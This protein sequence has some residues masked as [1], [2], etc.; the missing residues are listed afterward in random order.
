MLTPMLRVAHTCIW[1]PCIYVCVYV[2]M[3]VCTYAC[4]PSRMCVHHH[5][6]HARVLAHALLQ[7]LSPRG[8]P[9][10]LEQYM[11]SKRSLDSAREPE[12]ANLALNG[13]GALLPHP[14]ARY[15]ICSNAEL[16]SA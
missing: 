11:K 5:S 10:R 15:D 4:H 16:S 3:R 2:R 9:A 8:D 12:L 13:L 7:L 14:C 1:M 6:G